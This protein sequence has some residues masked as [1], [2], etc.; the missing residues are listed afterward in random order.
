VHGPSTGDRLATEEISALRDLH[1]AVVRSDVTLGGRT[2]TVSCYQIYGRTALVLGSDGADLLV[3]GG[4][5]RPIAG[6]VVDG[7]RVAAEIE[8][9]GCPTVLADALARRLAD[10]LSAYQGETTLDGQPVYRFGLGGVSDPA[11]VVL[12]RVDDLRPIE[13]RLAGPGGAGIGMLRYVPGQPACL[14][15]TPNACR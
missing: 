8:L 10:G 4:V 9:A 1:P 11:G 2:V 6:T 14:E 12:A 7:S 15:L 3:Q 13:V 5:A